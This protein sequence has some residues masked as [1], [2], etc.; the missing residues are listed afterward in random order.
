VET[1]SRYRFP[2]SVPQV[3]ATSALFVIS[4]LRPLLI[5]F[6]AIALVATSTS[7]DKKKSD[8]KDLPGLVLYTI[9]LVARTGEKQKIA[10][11]GKGL[12]AVK[13][14]KVVGVEDAKVKV[15]GGKAVT[16]PNNY[17]G[18]RVGDSEVEFELEL[19]RGAKPGEVKLVAIG[20]GGESPSY[21]LLLRDEL[22]AVA[23]K[24]PNDGFDQAQMIAIPCAVE[25]T[26]K[27]E[28]DVDVFKFEGKK[29][30]KL[31][32]EMQ[33]ARY[34]S[35]VDGILTFYDADRRV[36]DSA[37]DTAG[38]PDPI[39]NVALPKDGTYYLSVIDANDL[40]GTNFGYRLIVR[41]Q[42]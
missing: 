33:A 13:E 15:L 40:G 28:K 2:G 34:G 31:R 39:L 20:P 37:N 25:G 32:I 24:E 12:A 11:R 6:S 27:G 5:L 41:P 29:G 42:K 14:I 1:P 4:M 10:L 16:V 21:T 17:P 35:P 30:G 22:P 26:I 38:I 3:A 9:P 19:P 23:E 36:I 7:Q 18:E 8:K